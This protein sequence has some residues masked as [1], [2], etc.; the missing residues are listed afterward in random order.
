M[1]YGEFFIIKKP[2]SKYVKVA[3]KFTNTHQLDQPNSQHLHQ[4][5]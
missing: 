1:Q 4:K 5:T 3:L 2:P